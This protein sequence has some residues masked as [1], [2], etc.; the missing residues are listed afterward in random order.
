ME[1]FFL[2]KARVE[3]N[4]ILEHMDILYRDLGDRKSDFLYGR[5]PA[6]SSFR[7]VVK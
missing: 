3:I 1:G 5:S 6:Y 4:V 2:S 7:N